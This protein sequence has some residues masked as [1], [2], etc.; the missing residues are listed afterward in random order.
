M[1]AREA[2]AQGGVEGSGSPRNGEGN[3]FH[4]DMTDRLDNLRI[5]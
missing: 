2:P 1:A 4:T 3:R 5:W